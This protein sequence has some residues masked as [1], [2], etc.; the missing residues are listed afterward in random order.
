MYLGIKIT[1]FLGG[2]SPFETQ[3]CLHCVG[4]K[5]CNEDASVLYQEVGACTSTVTQPHGVYLGTTR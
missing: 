5:N 4:T 3:H 1:Q 2:Y